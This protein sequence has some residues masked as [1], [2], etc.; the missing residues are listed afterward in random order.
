MGEEDERTLVARPAVRRNG[1]AAV[2]L[3]VLSNANLPEIGKFAGCVL[4]RVCRWLE[5]DGTRQKAL[6]LVKGD[7]DL[8]V[9]KS[10]LLWGDESVDR[11]SQAWQDLRWDL[12]Q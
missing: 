12:R 3:A 6:D 9:K 1:V 7:I 2:H 5:V 11:F 4:S 10:F 8:P